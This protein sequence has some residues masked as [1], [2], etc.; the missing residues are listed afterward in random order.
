MIT[1]VEPLPD[2]TAYL[3]RDA[4]RR[5]EDE[6]LAAAREAGADPAFADWHGREWIQ[7]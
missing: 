7:R 3:V 2:L 5:R 1:M 6:L 4:L